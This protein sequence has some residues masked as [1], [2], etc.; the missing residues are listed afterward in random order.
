MFYIILNTKGQRIDPWGTPQLLQ[1]VKKKVILLHYPPMT[2]TLLLA[3]TKSPVSTRF[4]AS[5]SRI[6]QRGC[7]LIGFSWQFLPGRL[8]WISFFVGDFIYCVGSGC[9]NPSETVIKS[10]TGGFH[11]ADKGT[12][13]I[14]IWLM[15]K[16]SP[17]FCL[18]QHFSNER[19]FFLL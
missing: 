3:D 14:N 6:F 19:C 4:I 9:V 11:H 7:F 15:M 2:P 1:Q 5:Q 12:T 17:V 16:H 8:T 13:S 18:E 10:S